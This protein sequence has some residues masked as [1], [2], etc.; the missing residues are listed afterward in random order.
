[1]R[2]KRL[3]PAEGL[4]SLGRGV[5]QWIMQCRSPFSRGWTG[6][7]EERAIRLPLDAYTTTEEIVIRAAVPGLGPED[8]DVTVEGDTLTIRGTF[9]PL[10]P[11]V[12]YLFQERVSG[13]FRREVTINVPVRADLAEARFDKGVLTV[14]L[15]KGINVDSKVVQ[16][17]TRLRG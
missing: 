12:T 6:H 10:L 1:M 7:G 4:S 13:P 15:P 11:S 17:N 16:V 8:V 9:P 14:I 5:S 3:G 2:V